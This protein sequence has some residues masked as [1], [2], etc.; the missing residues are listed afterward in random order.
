[1][2]T[3]L[4]R[5]V[6]PYER[7]GI[8][9]G[10]LIRT[11]K[12]G[13]LVKSRITDHDPHYHAYLRRVQMRAPEVLNPKVKVEDEASLLRSII[14]GSVA[15]ARNMQIPKDV[16]DSNNRWRKVE[17]AGARQIT[18]EMIEYYSDVRAM[19]KALLGYSSRL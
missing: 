11:L 17:R 4:Q 16:I 3:W 2:L 18:V 1:M 6:D 12:N 5:L 14:K 7:K 10:P 8:I 19:I 9:K 13:K 15:Q